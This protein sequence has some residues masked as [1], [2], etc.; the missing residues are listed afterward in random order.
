[1][2]ANAAMATAST[3]RVAIRLVTASIMLSLIRSW[4]RLVV[5]ETSGVGAVGEVL[6]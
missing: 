4:T 3:S 6:G 2:T 1:M 5:A